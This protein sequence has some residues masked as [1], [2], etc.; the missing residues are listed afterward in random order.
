MVIEAEA[1]SVA[2]V[3]E[4]CE[5]A[6]ELGVAR[7]KVGDIEIQPSP[8]VLKPKPPEVPQ[9]E[10]EESGRALRTYSEKDPKPHPLAFY[11]SR[12]SIP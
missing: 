4:L 3:R 11:S 5:L 12:V 1:D 10:T 2:Y 8:F 7:L 6:I 9:Q